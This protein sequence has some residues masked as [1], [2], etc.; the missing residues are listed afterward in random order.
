MSRRC[1]PIRRS[2]R[3]RSGR[4]PRADLPIVTAKFAA[5]TFESLIAKLEDLK[6][7]F[8]PLATPGDL[9]DDRHLNESGRLLD[10]QL[11]T[12]RVARIPG[13][14]LDMGGRKTG[15]PLSTAE[16]GRAHAIHTC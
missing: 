9:F 1:S 13:I 6:I 4:R 16:N 11:P 5:E 15:T 7:P 2:K 3:I 8:G 14:P 10:V 12:G